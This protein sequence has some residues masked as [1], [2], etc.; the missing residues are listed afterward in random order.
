M[1]SLIFLLLLSFN[2]SAALYDRGNGLIYDDV[3]D[4]TWLQD[5]NYAGTTGHSGIQNFSNINGELPTNGVNWQSNNN[6]NTDCQS[7]GQMNWNNSKLWVENLEYGGFSNWRLP[8]IKNSIEGA[9]QTSSEIGH[10]FYNNL[11]NS[12]QQDVNCFPNCL[13][14][15]T[16]IDA[17]TGSNI[18][19]LNLNIFPHTLWFNEENS[20][21]ASDAWGFNYPN[22][23]Q[24]SGYGKQG[25]YQAW[26]VHDGD[27]GNPVPLPA[28]IYLFLS[29]VVGLGLMRGRNV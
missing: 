13:V 3:L 25:T 20:S 11:G 1:R 10:V 22:G 6:G 23:N 24:Y 16:G 14:N 12:S 26:A 28:G 18:N 5:A 7:V 8:S 4:I 27:I 2:A 9:N 19:F 21:T 17:S 15:T 29:G